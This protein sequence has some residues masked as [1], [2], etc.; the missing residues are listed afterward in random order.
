MN[1]F[2]NYLGI[3][4]KSILSRYKTLEKNIKNRSNSYY[5][6]YL[7]LFECT[8]KVLL[9]KNDVSF[10][11]S[12][13]F[14]ALLK[15]NNIIVYL[16]TIHI[17]DELYNKI[18]DYTKKANEHKHKDE[19]NV[20][21]EAVINQMRIY[22]EFI[23]KYFYYT[24]DINIGEYDEMYYSNIFGENERKHKEL[25]EELEKAYEQVSKLASDNENVNKALNTY[26]E[27]FQ[28]NESKFDDLEKSN[29]D[30]ENRIE[31]LNTIFLES[32]NLQNKQIDDLNKR[33]DKIDSNKISQEEQYEYNKRRQY[34]DG[35]TIKNFILDSKAYYLWSGSTKDFK[36]YKKSIITIF[37]RTIC[38]GLIS[39]LFTSLNFK[40]YAV[41]S[42]IE[43]IYLIISSI[44]IYR[45]SKSNKQIF[46]SDLATYSNMEFEITKD[47]IYVQ[48]GLEKKDRRMSI[49]L[50]LLIV[51]LNIIGMFIFMGD[52]VISIIAAVFE[53]CFAICY[54]IFS[55]KCS[56][57]FELYGP[58]ILFINKKTQK[59]IVFDSIARKYYSYEEYEEYEEKFKMF[60]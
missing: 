20:S 48:S 56:E 60:L 15:D 31:L 57:F 55:F 49:I 46:H 24:N 38:I 10:D 3:I 42:I 19:K 4:D 11:K 2:I 58:L 12:K 13:T 40:I 34:E 27:K 7:D 6:S 30:L 52:I 43:F 36:K 8:L 9:T 23:A 25:E 28:N 35:V 21:K 5:D 54:L 16:K 17:T 14:G 37:I 39:I 47:G 33:I 29:L 50:L 18:L 44:A 26:K 59:K 51:I 41:F 1:E 22:F 32:L 53:I 45:I